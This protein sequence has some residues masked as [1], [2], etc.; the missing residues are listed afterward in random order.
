MAIGF[1]PP[2]FF[3]RERELL[4]YGVFFHMLL[5]RGSGQRQHADLLSEAEDNLRRP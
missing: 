1:D 2:E 3:G 5:A 4:G